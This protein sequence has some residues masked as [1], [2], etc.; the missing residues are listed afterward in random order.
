MKYLWMCSLLVAITFP[1]ISHSAPGP[2]SEGVQVIEVTAKKYEFDPFPI[3]AKQG[4]KVQLNKTEYGSSLASN[5]CFA[6]FQ[7]TECRT[8]LRTRRHRV[9]SHILIGSNYSFV[10]RTE[11]PLPGAVE[12]IRCS[13]G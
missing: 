4:T 6:S 1:F 5:G 11:H 2:A 12:N 7:R 9:S 3:R 13:A 8:L 10:R